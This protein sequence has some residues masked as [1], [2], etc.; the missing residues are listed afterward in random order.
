MT[1]SKRVFTAAGIAFLIGGIYSPSTA[2]IP[3]RQ[4]LIESRIVMARDDSLRDVGVRWAFQ[5]PD[6]GFD[7]ANDEILEITVSGAF[8]AAFNKRFKGT[9]SARI[10]S[11][12]GQSIQIGSKKFKSGRGR[13]KNTFSKT[14]ATV[15]QTK[16]PLPLQ[17]QPDI[18]LKG[19][20][21]KTFL[22]PGGTSADVIQLSIVVLVEPR[23]KK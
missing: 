2:D 18:K 4:V 14:L 6:Q 10:W 15:D 13:N 23:K 11:N 8:E 1:R 16:H 12:N 3:I 21:I 7:L 20:Q 22:T 5:T 17:I 9:A 19:K